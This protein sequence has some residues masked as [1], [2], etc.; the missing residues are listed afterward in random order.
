MFSVKLVSDTQ[1][2]RKRMKHEREKT[3]VKLKKK[4]VKGKRRRTLA[5]GGVCSS[6]RQKKDIK[7]TTPTILACFYCFIQ[8]K[9]SF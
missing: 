3:V 2:E 4:K 6:T 8:V 9:F 5:T 1:R 7:M